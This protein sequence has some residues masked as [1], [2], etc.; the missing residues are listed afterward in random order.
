[1]VLSAWVSRWPVPAW[2]RR[3]DSTGIKVFLLLFL[4]KKK[5]LL[6][7]EENSLCLRTVAR[8]GFF[9]NLPG[10]GCKHVASFPAAPAVADAPAHPA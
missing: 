5:I 1:M 4:Q 3:W 6:F 10:L 8:T 2:L 9:L 7:S